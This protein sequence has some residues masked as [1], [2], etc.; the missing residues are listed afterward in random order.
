MK[1][2]KGYKAVALIQIFVCL[3][4][5]INPGIEMHGFWYGLINFT[6]A[7]ILFTGS[8]LAY[9]DPKKWTLW[10]MLLTMSVLIIINTTFLISQGV[11]LVYGFPLIAYDLLFVVINLHFL[12]KGL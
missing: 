9:Y 10:L 4:F 3:C 7:G 1:F 11:F 6:G 5:F 2:I 8:L 12:G